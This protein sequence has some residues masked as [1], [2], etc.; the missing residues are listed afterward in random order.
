MGTGHPEA[1]DRLRAISQYFQYSGMLQDLAAPSVPSSSE[2]IGPLWA[3]V[4]SGAMLERLRILS[5]MQGYAEIDADTRMNSH[6]LTAA[7][8][9]STAVLRAID[10][11]AAGE[12]NAAF[13]AIRP[14]GHHAER[15][16]PMGFCLV[17]HAAVAV[18][19]L[20][21]RL[22]ARAVA[23]LDFDVHHGN[24][25]VDIFRSDPD[26]LVCSSFQHPFYPGRHIASSASHLIHSP[27]EAGSN[28]DS[29]LASIDRDWLPALEQHQPE[30]I[31]F[32]AGFDAHCNDPLGGLNWHSEDYYKI[33]RRLLEVARASCGGRVLSLLEGGYDLDAL[34][35]SSYW[36][37]RALLET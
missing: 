25:T 14:P 17:N 2:L 16:T 22:G 36:H 19:Y 6:S 37:V 30:W 9:A 27:L 13:C 18:E 21:S 24:G 5:P 11:I 23:V 12:F 34:A 33:T 4:H 35:Q 15:A 3:K 29:V 8:I 26:T 1:P 31:I 7:R 28:A 32:S 10:G 20:R